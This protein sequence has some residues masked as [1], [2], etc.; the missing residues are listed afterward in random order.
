VKCKI[1]RSTGLGAA[2]K[3]GDLVFALWRMQRYEWL[4]EKRADEVVPLLRPGRERP[5]YSSNVRFLSW[6][7]DSAV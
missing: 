4:L 5:S 7:E 6:R 1:G 3:V 2:L